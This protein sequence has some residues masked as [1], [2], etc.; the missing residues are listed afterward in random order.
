[1]TTCRVVASPLP[2]FRVDPYDVSFT[3]TVEHCGRLDCVESRERDG[4]CYCACD[5]C[6]YCKC[7]CNQQPAR[8]GFEQVE[9]GRWKGRGAGYEIRRVLLGWAVRG[10]NGDIEDEQG[11]V[12]KAQRRSAL[13]AQQPIPTTMDEANMVATLH[14]RAAG[15]GHP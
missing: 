8:A 10:P 9:P 12:D 5:E 7:G 2:D 3:A 11:A 4:R 13:L 15:H 1:M 14:A 6:T